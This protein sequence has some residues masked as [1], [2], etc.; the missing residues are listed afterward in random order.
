MFLVTFIRGR[1]FQV[2]R[3]VRSSTVPGGSRRAQ[4][5]GPLRGSKEEITTCEP[6]I[7]REAI[8]TFPFLDRIIDREVLA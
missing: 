4:E 1:M 2:S 7:L 5:G 3:P 8:C 6:I